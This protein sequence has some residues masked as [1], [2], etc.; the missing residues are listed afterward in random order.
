MTPHELSIEEIQ[1]GNSATFSRTWTNDDV[2]MF[3]QIS[4][5]MNSLHMD[6]EYARTTKFRK[7][8]VHGMLLGSLCSTLVGVYLPGK[9]CLYLK[10]SLLFK[11]PV[12]I[13]DTIIV[14]GTVTGKSIVTSI[15]TI[16]ITMKKE[17]DIVLEG[18]ACVQVLPAI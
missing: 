13:G 15:L 10:Q 2:S 4:G 9:R 1:I 7:R 8:L 14:L 11:K 17:N 16:S 5:D 3:A 12:Y 6:D 18:E